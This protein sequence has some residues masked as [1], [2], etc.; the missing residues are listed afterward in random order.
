MAERLWQHCETGR[1]VWH[2]NPGSRWIE[3][4]VVCEDDLPAGMKDG[5]YELWYDNSLVVDGV[6]VGPMVARSH[7]SDL[8]DMLLWALRAAAL[9]AVFGLVLNVLDAWL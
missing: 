2:Q 3:V 9:T 5:E 4:S 7:P 8:K 1:M 6:R